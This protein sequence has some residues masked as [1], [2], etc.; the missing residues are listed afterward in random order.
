VV[1]F[2]ATMI[3]PAGFMLAP[4]VAVG[5]AVLTARAPRARRRKVLLAAG[6]CGAVAIGL[7]A[8]WQLADQWLFGRGAAAGAGFASTE[9]NGRQLS[10]SEFGSYLWQFWIPRP[11]GFMTDQFAEYPFFPSRDV[12][13]YGFVG[14]FGWFQYD[15]GTRTEQLAAVVLAL[16]LA[17]AAVSLFRDRAALRG[18]W[19]EG[20]TYL[21]L[22]GGVVLLVNAA[23]YRY[24]LDTGHSF[25]QTR[26]LFPALLP[27]WGL[28]VALAVS[29]VRGRW[30]LPL[31]VFV[32]VLLAGHNLAAHLLT[33]QRYYL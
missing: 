1:G 9:V 13:F 18:R 19:G 6:A 26:Y 14:R 30:R 8:A 28:A 10:L 12:Y 24:R 23:G 27:M 2:V 33:V 21:A 15:F 17:A 11:L 3:K 22:L 29:V 25:E 16:L 31:A 5:L 32:A 4:G 20:A 7:L